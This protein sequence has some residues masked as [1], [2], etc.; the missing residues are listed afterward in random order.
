MI[1]AI[2][3]Q[4]VLIIFTVLDTDGVTPKTGEAGNVAAVLRDEDGAASESVVISEQGTSGYYEAVF[5][6]TNGSSDGFAYNLFI[7]EPAG[8]F[9][10]VL[11]WDVRSFNSVSFPGVGTGDVLTSL[12][13]VKQYLSIT[14][15]AL[16]DFLTAFIARATA[17]IQDYCQYTFFQETYTE[18]HDGRNEDIIILHERPII[19]VTSVHD[20]VDRNFSAEHLIDPS[21]YYPDLKSG[22]IERTDGGVFYPNRRNVQVI[23]EAGY[24]VIPNGL[25]T[26]CVYLVAHWFRGRTTIGKKSKTIKDAGNVSYKDRDFPEDVIQLLTPFRKRRIA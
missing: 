23:Y 15:S 24:A 19:S 11:G 17:A 10:R 9:G 1:N 5:T 14:G 12:A 16:D 18:L 2:K 4:Q 13:N 3:D 20:D 25:E 21:D 26:A 6:P 22:I 7:T 8:T